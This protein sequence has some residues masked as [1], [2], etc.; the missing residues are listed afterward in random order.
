MKRSIPAIVIFTLFAPSIISILA[1]ASC[2]KAEAA[3]GH[4]GAALSCKG[5]YKDLKGGYKY[6]FVAEVAEKSEREFIVVDVPRET[7]LYSP[8]MERD[9]NTGGYIGAFETVVYRANYIQGKDVFDI[10]STNNIF[11]LTCDR[12]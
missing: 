3:T 8:K 2:D 12:K 11:T 6:D 4:I 1:L 10:I 5:E 9:P 7:S